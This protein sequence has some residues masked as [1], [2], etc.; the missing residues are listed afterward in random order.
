M[1]LSKWP[2]SK[3]VRAAQEFEGKTQTSKNRIEIQNIE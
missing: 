1:K 3:D 2:K